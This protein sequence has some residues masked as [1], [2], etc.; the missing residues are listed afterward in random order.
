MGYSNLWPL[1]FISL[2]SALDHSAMD[3]QQCVLLITN[4]F[5]RHKIN[6]DENL[7]ILPKSSKRLCLN[8][9]MK[10]KKQLLIL[11]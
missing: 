6:E 10:L 4:N 1:K 3:T 8:M 9:K 7:Q 5:R 11:H 2:T